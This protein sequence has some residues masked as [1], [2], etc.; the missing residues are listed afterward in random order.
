MD[1]TPTMI[2]MIIPVREEAAL[3]W[4][5]AERKKK[6]NFFLFFNFTLES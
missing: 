4:L 1:R 3:L 5:G 6:K 2:P